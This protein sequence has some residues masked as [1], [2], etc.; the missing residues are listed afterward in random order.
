LVCSEAGKAALSMKLREYLACDKIMTEYSSQLDQDQRKDIADRKRMS[1]D[2]A[3]E[4]LIHAYNTVVKCERDVLRTQEIG[5]FATD[6]AAQITVKTLSELHENGV[7]LRKIGLN[8]INRNG[9]MPTIEKPV[10]VNEL[11][12]AFLRFDDK[13]MILNVDAVKDT[14]NRYCEEGMWNVGTGDPEH[15]SRIYHNETIPFLNPQEDGYW[16]LDPSVMPKP[17]GG[18]AGPSPEPGPT[19]TPGPAPTPGPEPAPTPATKTYKRVT[20]SGSVP[21]ENYS[22]LFS[23]FVNTLKNNHL[24][25]EVKFTA[26]NNPTNPLTDNSPI[27]KSVKESASQLGLEFEVE[28]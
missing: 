4:Q 21:I 18:G 28:E 10:K 23:S 7:V 9:L 15:F 13:P 8:I 26:S 3:K 17:A 6:F 22:Q 2:A 12:E 27:V 1:G 16:L 11:Y 5:T 24:K 25:I 19:P 14:V 20:I